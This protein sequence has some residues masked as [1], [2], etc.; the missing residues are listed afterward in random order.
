MSTAEKLIVNLDQEHGALRFAILLSFI[1]AWVVLFILFSA[2]IPNQGFS[3]L[4]IILGFAG[5]YLLAA[6][7]ERNLKGRWH[8]GRVIEID[9]DGV[10]MRRGTTLD[11]E[12]LSEDP[13]RALL[14]RFTVTKRARVP[15][16]TVMF[17][18]ALQ[19]EDTYLTV[20]TFVPPKQVDSFEFADRFANLL[21]KKQA[22]NEQE[23]LR[24][25]GEQRRLR[26]AENNRWARGGEMSLVDFT[27]Y[28]QR[29][30]AQYPEWLD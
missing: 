13:A 14:W 25:A 21:T 15:K 2:L 22:A 6:L 3:L 20:Y 28:I 16:G 19:F 26:D 5:A 1:G 9:Q 29:L 7:L 24:L 23:D 17:A 8:S 10:R 18:C 30:K 4:A 27:T 11:G 12:I